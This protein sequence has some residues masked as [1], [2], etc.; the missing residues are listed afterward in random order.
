MLKGTRDGGK[1]GRDDG[2]Y[3][4]MRRKGVE[5]WCAGGMSVER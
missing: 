1:E 4:C 5:G 3:G 2:V